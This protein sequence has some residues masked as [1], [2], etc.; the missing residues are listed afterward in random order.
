MNESAFD[1]VPADKSEYKEE[2]KQMAKALREHTKRVNDT[3][4]K[5]ADK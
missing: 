5:Y 1:V 4:K 2:Y 3:V